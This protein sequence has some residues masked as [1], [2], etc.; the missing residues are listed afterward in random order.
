MLSI[1]FQLGAVVLG[2]E[3][4]VDLMLSRSGLA[5]W[6]GFHPSSMDDILSLIRT[7]GLS[8]QQVLLLQE[9][10]LQVLL[11][12]LTHRDFIARIDN[13]IRIRRDLIQWLVLQP[14]TY[15]QCREKLGKLEDIDSINHEC[16]DVEVFFYIT[17]SDCNRLICLLFLRRF[18]FSGNH[19]LLIPGDSSSE[20]SIFLNLIHSL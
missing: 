13:R 19:H 12:L 18:V 7:R 9:S 4:F 5:S 11:T 6:L 17:S 8:S 10:W 1:H 2:C 14:L 3:K 16:Y 20:R 15:S